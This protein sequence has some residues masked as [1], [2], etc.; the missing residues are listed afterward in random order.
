MSSSSNYLGQDP[1]LFQSICHFLMS[2][3]HFYSSFPCNQDELDAMVGS[4]V[5]P[6]GAS[7]K[8]C[9]KT[10]PQK[11]H[12]RSAFQLPTSSSRLH[13]ITLRKD[14][15]LRDIDSE[16][17]LFA[18]MFHHTTLPQ[19]R[20]IRLLRIARNAADSMSVTIDTFALD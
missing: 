13:K 16:A 10:V 4:L 17:A 18:G 3:I 1:L 9:H 15:H 5:S 19:E 20:S 2:G 8:P 12:D 7:L 6:L 11:H 14:L